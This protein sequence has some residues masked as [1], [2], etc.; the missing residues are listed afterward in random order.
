MRLEK[1]EIK[2]KNEIQIKII[3]PENKNKE[4]KK[5]KL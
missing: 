3:I 2:S 1:S 4:E 5:F